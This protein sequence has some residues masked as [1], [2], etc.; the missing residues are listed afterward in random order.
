M[1]L[2]DV[3]G[4]SLSY[5]IGGR[6][7]AILADV[8]FGIEAGEFVA[9]QGPSGSGKSTL[10]YILG[11]L[12]RPTRGHVLFAGADLTAMSDLELARFRNRQ[13]GF[14]FQQFH[15]LPRATVLDN[16]LLP[17]FYPAELPAAA[18]STRARAVALAERFGLTDFLGQMPNQL[19]GGQQQRVAIARALMHDTRVILA[20]EPTGNLD[21]VNADLV[22]TTLAELHAEGRTVVLITHDPD[23][24]R[25]AG[26]CLTVRDGRVV[27][28]SLPAATNGSAP[29][30][31]AAPGRTARGGAHGSSAR[32]ALKLLP[33]A[34]GNL[35][36]NKVKSLLTMLG[37][38]IGVAAV[39]AMITTG[40]FTK[41]KI[42]E[43]YESLGVNKIQMR[44]YPARNRKS[45]RGGGKRGTKDK[46]APSAIQFNAF[47][48][49]RDI[50]SLPRIFPQIQTL[51]PVLT[52]W[53]A[54]LTYGGRTWNDE[55]RGYGVSEAYLAILNHEIETGRGFS[56]FHVENRNPVCII[57][58]DVP[59]NLQMK[60]AVGK[61]ISV[62]VGEEAAFPCQVI[63]VMR[64]QS[65]NNNSYQP[66]KIVLL[67]YTYL[68]TAV[69]GWNSEIHE[70]A[71]KLREGSDVETTGKQIRGFFEQKYG[72]SGQFNVDSD[73]TLVAQMKR[74]LTIFSLLLG[75]IAF[76]SLV[77]GGIG[78]HNMMLVSVADR[79]KE[80]GL[81]KAL[82]AT[83]RSVRLQVLGESIL[84]CATA[85]AVG[86]ALGFAV[87]GL[88]MYGATKL[89]PK[90]E[91][92]WVINPWAVGLSC[93]SIVAV[94]IISGLAPA[95]K[96]EKLQVIEALR[97]E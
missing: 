22:M 82:G 37:V 90:L 73:S 38:I 5:T 32:L 64:S 4:L 50:A 61:I 2:F 7:Q 31:R 94:G 8:S 85:G 11:G 81:R 91:F 67:P 72:D 36:R 77:V 39:L 9:V 45:G 28:G 60:G 54:S 18:E 68:R 21:S 97:S 65:S 51:S 76:L 53:N 3:R 80:I 26:R 47:D 55:I 74:F 43:G 16:I 87:C 57:G 49:R 62:G 96:A 66:N 83:S 78:I 40:E 12:L 41:S 25:R 95:V 10:F 34:V 27:A 33:L 44:G 30:A 52:I 71:I 1:P 88:M 13:I 69:A 56:P 19:S 29:T 58:A 15:L 17:A 92:E 79:I 86:L 6:E 48:E 93:L 14:V 42:L 23:V 20:D 35:W 46:A 63:G 59:E 89:M 70:V 75:G 84:L 24:A